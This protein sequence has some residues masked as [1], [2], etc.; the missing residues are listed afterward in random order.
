MLFWVSSYTAHYSIKC[1]LINNVYMPCYEY[2]VV[3]VR[4]SNVEVWLCMM[5]PESIGLRKT[6][7]L[8]VDHTN[9]DDHSYDLTIHIICNFISRII[10]TSFIQP[11]LCCRCHAVGQSVCEQLVSGQLLQFYFPHS[12]YL[13]GL[14]S[15]WMEDTLL[16]LTLLRARSRSLAINSLQV[17][18]Q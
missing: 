3:M 4:G 8:K 2:L 16:I 11:L 5:E 6:V 1:F 14:C 9:S 10:L 7:K 17:F 15:Q 12:L 13:I 18:R